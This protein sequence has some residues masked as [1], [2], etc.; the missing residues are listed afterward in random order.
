[1]K[2]I[3]L[4]LLLLFLA[5]AIDLKPFDP[6]HLQDD[7]IQI[8]VQGAIVQEGIVKLARYATVEDALKQVTLTDQADRSTL[9]PMQILH[10]R[11]VL[12]IPE[13][14]AEN[15]EPRLS[16]NTADAE[17]LASLP[18]IGPAIAERIVCYRDENGLFQTLGDL[19]NVKGIGE[20]LFEKLK[21]R[22]C[23]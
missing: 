3:L 1:M 8:Y 23:L 6:Q 10:D 11:D 19:M 17:Q 13:K 7:T 22:I 14:K 16:V 15:Q 4:F 12:Y 5:L 20:R 21:D 2:Q 18:G 9:N